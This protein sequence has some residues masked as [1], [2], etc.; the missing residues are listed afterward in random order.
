[1]SDDSKKKGDYHSVVTFNNDNDD[2]NNDD[3]KF[4]FDKFVDTTT[5]TTKKTSLNDSI[6]FHADYTIP[7]TSENSGTSVVINNTVVVNENVLVERTS[8]S[9]QLFAPILVK[10]AV[11]MALWYIASFISIMQNKYLLSSL[12][13]D[14]RYENS[15]FLIV[16]WLRCGGA[17]HWRLIY[18]TIIV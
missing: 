10:Q 17:N 14:P 5:T 15:S 8:S 1:M 13:L 4:E 16:V 11:L 3:A 9:S 2:D 18:L 7:G 6:H 12:D